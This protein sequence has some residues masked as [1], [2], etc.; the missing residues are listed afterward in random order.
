[1]KFQT[2]WRIF[3]FSLPMSYSL[4]CFTIFFLHIFK[5]KI[6]HDEQQEI[7]PPFFNQRQCQCTRSAN[8][9][10]SLKKF[11]IIIKQFLKKEVVWC[12]QLRQKEHITNYLL[13]RV[14]YIFHTWYFRFRMI[15]YNIIIEPRN[16]YFY[17]ITCHDL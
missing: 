3:S 1:M 10:F 2:F 12:I 16:T 4:Y 13:R 15:F 11:E 9:I 7:T 17:C 8:S 5:K 14:S 6:D